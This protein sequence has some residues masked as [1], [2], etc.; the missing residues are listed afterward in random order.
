MT[1][2]WVSHVRKF[3][4]EKGLSY[5]CALSDPECKRSYIRPE[6]SVK[7]QPKQNLIFPS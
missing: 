4:S 6:K 7:K 1:N 2:N 5:G 3:A